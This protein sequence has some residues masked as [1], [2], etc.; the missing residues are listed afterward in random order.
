MSHRRRTRGV[1]SI[2]AALLVS[3]A[4]T[5]QAGAAPYPP[6]AYL[7]VVLGAAGC[8]PNAQ[9]AAIAGFMRS[10]PG[11]RR[12]SLTCNPILAS[13]ARSRAT[14]MAARRYFSHVNPDGIGPNYLVR[15]A[16]YNLPGGYD[17]TL[18]GNNIESI[19]AGYGTAEEAWQGWM[20][21]E[22]HRSHLLGLEPFWAEQLEYGVGYAYLPGSE[23]GSYWV[24][25]TARH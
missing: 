6:R 15:Q 20:G 12:P 22:G 18:E 16:G 5:V 8:S 25:I 9:E 4:F 14:D 19:A 23:Y 11:Q 3:L 17:G 10:E 24:V 1:T 21:S 2:L 7:P 13:V